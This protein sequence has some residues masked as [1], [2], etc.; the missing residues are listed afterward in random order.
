MLVSN[1][2]FD[3][4]IFTYFIEDKK[5]SIKATESNFFGYKSKLNSFLTNSGIYHFYENND[6]IIIAS[7]DT[8]F[9]YK[10]FKFNYNKVDNDLRLGKIISLVS[11]CFAITETTKNNLLILGKTKKLVFENNSF[12]FFE[13]AECKEALVVQLNLSTKEISS[14]TIDRDIKW[15]IKEPGGLFYSNAFVLNG[16]LYSNISCRHNINI[17]VHD[18]ATKKLIANN[19]LEEYYQANPS[20]NLGLQS[21]TKKTIE[22]IDDLKTLQAGISYHPIYIKVVPFS[23]SNIQVITGTYQ[24]EKKLTVGDVLNAALVFG[25]ASFLPLGVVIPD[26][27]R[28]KPVSGFEYDPN[29]VGTRYASTILHKNTNLINQVATTSMKIEKQEV[30]ITKPE[31]FIKIRSEKIWIDIASNYLLFSYN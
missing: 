25:V 12:Y 30:A 26:F 3:T 10:E 16:N 4:F 17:I 1:G 18:I 11:D 28:T 15:C 23:D 19:S 22:P 13:S 2:S 9:N 7:L 27:D 20:N 29:L 31:V 21:F 24:I 6:Q 5:A 8:N 14:Y